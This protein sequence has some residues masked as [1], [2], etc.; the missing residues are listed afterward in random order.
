[1]LS[2]L[3]K[4]MC[5]DSTQTGSFWLKFRKRSADQAF[6]MTKSDGFGLCFVFGPP[7]DHCRFR[8]AVQSTIPNLG[9]T[10]HRF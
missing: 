2:A 10:W 5:P 7:Q 3:N 8:Q 9:K 4:E 6:G 1:M